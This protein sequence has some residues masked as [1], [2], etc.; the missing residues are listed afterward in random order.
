M[1]RV[2]VTNEGQF[3]FI[4]KRGIAVAVQFGI[5]VPKRYNIRG[6]QLQPTGCLVTTGHGMGL[7][8]ADCSPCDVFNVDKGRKLA[9]E[10][11]LQYFPEDVRII[12][13]QAVFDGGLIRK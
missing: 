6:Q 5:N 11:A 4:T 10:R 13:W 1:D 7:G 2:L 3:A 12:A 8:R 9:L